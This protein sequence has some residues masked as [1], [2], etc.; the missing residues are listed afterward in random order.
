M[1]PKERVAAVY[2]LEPPDRVPCTELCVN[3]PVASKLLGRDAIIGFG[4]YIRG[5]VHNSMLASGR[6]DEYVERFTTDTLAVNRLLG[7]DLFQ[8][9]AMPARGE[10]FK[11]KEVAPNVWR[12]E[13][14]HGWFS[15]C[16]YDPATDFY[17]EEDSSFIRDPERELKRMIAERRRE[18]RWVPEEGVFDFARRARR[19]FPDHFLWGSAGFGMPYHEPGITSLLEHT[20]LWREYVELSCEWNKSWADAQLAEGV[21]AFWDGSDWAAKNGPFLSPALF[22]EIFL[23]GYAELVRHLHA[24]GVKFVKHTDGN[25]GALEDMWFGEAGVDGFHAIEPSAGMDIVALRRRWPRLLLHGNL[26]CGALLTLGTKA[27][28]EDEV[29][30]LVTALAPTSGWVFSSSNSIHSGIP[31]ENVLAM[32][33]ALRH[34]GTAPYAPRPRL[35]AA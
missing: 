9:H 17:G 19:E 25:I 10:V 4:G 8:I 7:F 2:A 26:D 15:E 29:V 24:R 1:T 13:D 18:P 16:R 5:K 23:P 34:H 31:P 21:D 3:H 33:E 35:F 30:R 27:Q 14:D 32:L 11:I 20:A 22:R 28:I 6:R 12:W